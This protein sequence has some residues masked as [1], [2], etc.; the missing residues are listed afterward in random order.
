MNGYDTT[1][2]NDPKRKVEFT[3]YVRVGGEEYEVSVRDG[4]EAEH[5]YISVRVWTQIDM[6]GQ[7]CSGWHKWMFGESIYCGDGELAH[8]CIAECF[9]RQRAKM[10]E[11]VRS[12]QN[13]RGWAAAEKGGKRRYYTKHANS[14]L[15]TAL[16]YAVNWKIAKAIWKELTKL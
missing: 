11:W 9:K 16:G 13:F 4:Q 8:E 10:R 14:C 7:A 1:T 5:L 3:R 15:K 12:W 2:C 6:R